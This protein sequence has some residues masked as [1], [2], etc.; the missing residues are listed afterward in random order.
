VESRNPAQQARI[1]NVLNF[2]LNVLQATAM[3]DW[4]AKQ[5]AI[6]VHMGK[7][8]SNL[9]AYLDALT[10]A[11]LKELVSALNW[12]THVSSGAIAGSAPGPRDDGRA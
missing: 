3:S 9:I 2:A 11:Q 12:L 6:D 5:A 4:D 7:Y 10:S 8:D 1:I